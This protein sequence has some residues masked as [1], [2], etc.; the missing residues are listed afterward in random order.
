MVDAQFKSFD[1]P[2]ETIEFPNV[3]S[4]LVELGDITVGQIVTAPG[5]RW[6]THMRPTVAESGVRRGTWAS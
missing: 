6:S 2:D 3:V 4:R 1:R 5:W